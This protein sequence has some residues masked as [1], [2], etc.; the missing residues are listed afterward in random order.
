MCENIQLSFS[1]L[2]KNRNILKKKKTRQATKASCEQA[3]KQNPL[4]N[5]AFVL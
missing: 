3:K 4:Q 5:F 2:F 1:H